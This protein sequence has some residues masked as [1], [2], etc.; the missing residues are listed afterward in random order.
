MR[1]L[2]HAFC[3]LVFAVCLAH[4]GCPKPQPVPL[5][6]DAADGAACNAAPD[7]CGYC[8]HMRAL[9]CREGG[10][11][12]AGASCEAVTTTVQ[13]Q[14]IAAMDLGCRTRAGSCDDA[15]NRCR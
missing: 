2:E 8:A 4:L 10:N 11:T 15:N 1:R 14:P 9:G 13:K 5:H 3:A 6:P 7:V 12:P